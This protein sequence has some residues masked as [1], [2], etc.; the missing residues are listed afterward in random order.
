M[1]TIKQRIQGTKFDP[2]YGFNVVP[3]GKVIIGDVRPALLVL[4]VAVTVVL[5]IA[6]AN[7][8]NLLLARASRREKEISI[9]AALGASRRRLVG[10]LLTESVLLGLMWRM[11]INT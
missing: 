10:Q 11:I 8:A 9:R 3:L 5:F 4:L 6:V 7:I 1:R 2:K